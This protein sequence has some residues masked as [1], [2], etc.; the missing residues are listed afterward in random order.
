MPTFLQSSYKEIKMTTPFTSCATNA[1]GA[2]ASGKGNHSG[3][4]VP[5][6]LGGADGPV[7]N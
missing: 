4:R 6:S 5:E 7:L 1:S 2:F 3:V